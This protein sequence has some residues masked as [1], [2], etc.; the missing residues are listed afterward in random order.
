MTLVAGGFLEDFQ[1]HVADNSGLGFVVGTNF[2]I[3]QSPDPIQDFPTI[4]AATRMRLT[5]YESTGTLT[6]MSRR[7]HQERTFRFVH[8]GDHPQDAVNR[9]WGL[10][11][12]FENDNLHVTFPSNSF[13]YRFLRTATLPTIVAS[14]EDGSA[15]ADHNM[16]L[17]VLNKV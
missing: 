6:R 12:W 9:A 17:L 11:E 7:I 14:S 5:I 16:T 4:L 10:V 13:T 3:G 15:L 8:R 1:D 2:T